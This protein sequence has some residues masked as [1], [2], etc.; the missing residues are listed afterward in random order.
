MRTF[1]MYIVAADLLDHPII[2]QARG[3]HEFPSKRTTGRYQ[4][5]L[6]GLG[7]YR[8]CRH[9]GNSRVIVLRD[10]NLVFLILYRGV[11]AKCS[12]A[13]INTFF[14]RV[15]FGDPF[16]RFYSNGQITV[17]ESRI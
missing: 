4:D 17:A 3:Q 16:F 6:A 8:Q 9:T 14:F 1:S 7:H 10:H 12:A 15:N 2:N 13:Q 11:F 5:L